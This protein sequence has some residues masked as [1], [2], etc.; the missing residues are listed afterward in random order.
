MI[1]EEYRERELVP[2]FSVKVTQYLRTSPRKGVGIPGQPVPQYY[3][4]RSLNALFKPFFH[5]GFVL[6]GFEEPTFEE[7]MAR[8]GL[9]WRNFT[10][11]PPVLLARMRL[12]AAG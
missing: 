3:F 8:E 5:A 11:I 12:P 10:Q 7:G 6:D 4:D 9:S 1:E 2:V